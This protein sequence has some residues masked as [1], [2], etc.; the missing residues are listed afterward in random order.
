LKAL[1]IGHLLKCIFLNGYLSIQ[2][3]FQ[4]NRLPVTDLGK[5]VLFG[6]SRRFWPMQHTPCL[7]AKR[8]LRF[9]PLERGLSGVTHLIVLPVFWEKLVATSDSFLEKLSHYSGSMPSGM[10]HIVT[11]GANPG[12]A[13]PKQE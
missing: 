3:K 10:A 8:S 1:P 6:L 4:H 5:C 12:K 13:K 11:A 2:K 9:S 7:F